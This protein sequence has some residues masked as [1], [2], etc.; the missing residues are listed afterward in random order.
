MYTVDVIRLHWALCVVP[1]GLDL[2]EVPPGTSVP[3][4]RLCR[5]FCTIA[6]GDPVLFYPS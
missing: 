5:S 6:S 2:R 1:S 3:G 4:Y